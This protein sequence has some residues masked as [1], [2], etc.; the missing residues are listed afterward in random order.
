[1]HKANAIGG[2]LSMLTAIAWILVGL[3]GWPAWLGI[4]VSILLGGYWAFG[5]QM[6]AGEEMG[7]GRA[8][9]RNR[10]R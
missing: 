2:I 9:N 1:M 4:V 6:V 3:A 8:R 10:H 5:R 7:P